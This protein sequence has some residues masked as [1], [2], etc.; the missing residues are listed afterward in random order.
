VRQGQKIWSVTS[1]DTTVEM[2]APVEGMVTSVNPRVLK[3]PNRVTDDPYGEGWILTL[4]APQLAT[5]LKNLLPVQMVR[6]WMHNSL[7]RVGTLCAEGATAL[8]GGH[9]VRGALTRVDPRIDPEVRRRMIK[10]FFLL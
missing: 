9:P 3:D 8:D 7:E 6:A 1:G 4:Q 2:A 10:E 5:C